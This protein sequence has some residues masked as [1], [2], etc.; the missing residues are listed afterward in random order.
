VWQIKKDLGSV[1]DITYISIDETNTV[2]QWK[3]M[4]QKGEIP[5]RS[6]LSYKQMNKMVLNSGLIVMRQSA[7]KRIK[8]NSTFSWV[9]IGNI[10]VNGGLLLVLTQVLGGRL[11]K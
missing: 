3:Q 7:L 10:Y 1:L 9:R 6:L 11:F 2:A 8:F 4:M 5:G